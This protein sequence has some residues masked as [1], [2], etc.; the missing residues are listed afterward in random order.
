M[1]NPN[2]GYVE[3]ETEA[4][5]PILSKYHA[6]DVG[7]TNPFSRLKQRLTGRTRP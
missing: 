5:E 6:L 7:A 1:S 3:R 4:V 2:R